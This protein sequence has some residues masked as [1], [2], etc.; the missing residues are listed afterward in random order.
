MK[1]GVHKY[2]QN[3]RK[4]KVIFTVTGV[5]A[6]VWLLGTATFLFDVKNTRFAVLKRTFGAASGLTPGH[7]D[8]VVF[9]IRGIT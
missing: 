8:V 9:L 3:N 5:L 4:W 6:L 2:F 7:D 1:D